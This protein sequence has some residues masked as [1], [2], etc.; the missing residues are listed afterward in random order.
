MDQPDQP[1][2]FPADELPERRDE[3]WELPDTGPV[4]PTREGLKKA[5]GLQAALSTKCLRFIVALREVGVDPSLTVRQRFL[6][7]ITL[8]SYNFQLFLTGAVDP[9]ETDE[10]VAEGRRAWGRV[11]ELRKDLLASL[12]SGPARAVIELEAELA[13]IPL[14][15]LE[16]LAGD[17][18]DVDFEFDDVSPIDQILDHCLE[19]ALRETQEERSLP[20]SLRFRGLLSALPVEWLDA[21]CETVDIEPYRLRKD[22]ERALGALLTDLEELENVLYQLAPEELDALRFLLGR[23]GACKAMLVTRRFGDDADDAHFWSERPP[24]SVLGQ[25]RLRGLVFIGRMV[26]G[27]QKHR[28]AAIPVELRQPMTT[29]LDNVDD[30]GLDPDA[31]LRSARRTAASWSEGAFPI[32]DGSELL[33]EDRDLAEDIVLTVA[34]LMATYQGELPHEWSA[35][36]L[37]ECL[38]EDVPRKISADNEYFDAIPDTMIALLEH[39]ADTGELEQ[40][41]KLAKLVASE[42]DGIRRAARDPER[43]GMAKNFVMA[44]QTEGVDPTDPRQM[45][46]FIER[47]NQCAAPP[48]EPRRT[49]KI[50]RNQPCPC[51]SGKKYKRCCG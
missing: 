43:W 31:L 27:K 20:L 34:E 29:A 11:N 12:P 37:M 25:L 30:A 38:T 18:E 4:P 35:S 2:L 47:W 23:D 17:D 44:A 32:P 45:G 50:G 21:I 5:F 33:D 26:H 24:V 49:T 7:E 1:L 42:V 16:E 3:T 19:K 48:P 6:N 14:D 15:E 8:L 22:R 40:G 41:R 39:L 28:T 10:V 36:A 51:G 46:G 13:D 9:E